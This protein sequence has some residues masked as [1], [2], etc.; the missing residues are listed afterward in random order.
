MKKLSR[1][2]AMLVISLLV[3]QAALAQLVSVDELAER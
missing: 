3:S 2:A 1:Y